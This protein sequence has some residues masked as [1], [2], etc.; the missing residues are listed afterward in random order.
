MFHIDDAM[1]EFAEKLLLPQGESFD[2]ERRNIIRCMESKDIQACPG[3]GKTTTLLAK[4]TILARQLPLKSNQGVCVLTHTN[5][6]VDEIRDRLE[7]IG[8]ILFQYPNH[9]GTIQSF[10]NRFLAIPAYIDMFGKR[11]ARID[12]EFFWEYTERRA[13]SLDRGVKY[14]LDQRKISIFDLRFNKDDFSISKKFDGPILMNPDSKSYPILKEFKMN[15]LQ[16]GVLCY[17][18]AYALAYYYITQLS[19]LNL[20]R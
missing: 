19:Q 1:I 5:V 8:D 18:D 10:V 11:P 20:G 13:R 7:G 9:F 3:S 14:W 16:Q 4:L 15:I 17:D 12:D 2:Q 6:A